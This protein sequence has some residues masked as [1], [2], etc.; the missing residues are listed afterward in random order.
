M[1]RYTAGLYDTLMALVVLQSFYGVRRVFLMRQF[2]LRHTV[3]ELMRS[4]DGLTD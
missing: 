4:R 3:N 1:M 2:Y